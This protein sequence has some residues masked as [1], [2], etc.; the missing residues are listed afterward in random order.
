[1]LEPVGFI[2]SALTENREWNQYFVPHRAS[3]LKSSDFVLSSS[4][5]SPNPLAWK[6]WQC[7]QV[8]IVIRV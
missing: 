8:Q 3:Y 5:S 6:I 7:D 4:L 1:M 2:S